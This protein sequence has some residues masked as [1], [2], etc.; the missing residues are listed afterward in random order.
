MNYE[1][2]SNYKQK[3]FS[4]RCLA[5]LSWAHPV[6]VYCIYLPAIAA[7]LY[8]ASGLITTSYELLLFAGGLISWTLFEYL[9]HRYFFHMPAENHRTKWFL[10]I[11]HGMHQENPRDKAHLFM[12][13]IPTAV[14]SKAIY[15]SL[16]LLIGWKSL[17]FSAGFLSGYLLYGSMHYAIHTYMPPKMLT[18]L[19]RNHTKHHYQTRDKGFGVSTVLWDLVF[20]TVPEKQE[21]KICNA[22]VYDITDFQRAR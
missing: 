18:A 10:Y 1:T 9:I 12:P 11:M 4:G 22:E 21:Q 17:A 16:Y 2:F 7:M 14:L 5:Y 15:L 13:V 20:G 3:N 6:V 8:Y 19:W